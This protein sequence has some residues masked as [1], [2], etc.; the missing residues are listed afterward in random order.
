MCPPN[1]VLKKVSGTLE[2]ALKHGGYEPPESS[3]HL[4]QQP[5][6]DECLQN[7]KLVFQT[8]QRSKWGFSAN[9]NH[10]EAKNEYV[11]FAVTSAQKLMQRMKTGD[12]CFRID[13]SSRLKNQ[14]GMS[15]AANGV[16]L[17]K[18][19]GYGT[20]EGFRQVYAHYS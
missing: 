12:D 19:A 9:R 1:S 11:G 4:F 16:H 7:R 20:C 18:N 10:W 17:C 2:A 13:Q 6:T 14:S 5:A 8:K 15:A 3:R